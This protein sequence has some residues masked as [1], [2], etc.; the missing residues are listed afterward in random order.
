MNEYFNS[1]NNFEQ[2]LTKMGIPKSV[3]ESFFS[4]L[5]ESDEC[6]CGHH[7]DQK[8][9]ENINKNKFRF[10]TDETYNVLNPIKIKITQTTNVIK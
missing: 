7:M 1:L 5:I 10:L 8:M 9:R 3:G 2:N 6:L 4:E